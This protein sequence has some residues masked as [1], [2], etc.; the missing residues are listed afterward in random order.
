[1]LN[2][3]MSLLKNLTD[4]SSNGQVRGCKYN[5][6]KDVDSEVA[7]TAYWVKQYAKDN[8]LFVQKFARA[9]QKMISH[10]YT[11]LKDVTP[12]SSFG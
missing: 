11:N 3:D 4:V 8:A 10:G 2:A 1:M 5:T 12:G 6:C 9:F 7:N